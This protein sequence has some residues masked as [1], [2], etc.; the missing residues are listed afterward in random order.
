MEI[1][2]LIAKFSKA[3][4]PYIIWIC[5][6]LA[7]RAHS[8][9]LYLYRVNASLLSNYQKAISTAF[10]SNDIIIHGIKNAST[11]LDCVMPS[12]SV[13]ISYSTRYNM[14]LILLR[15][16]S[17]GTWGNRLKECLQRRLI[18]AC[19]DS[20]CMEVCHKNSIPNCVRLN[21]PV[22]PAS[23]FGEN[24]FNFITYLKYE[25]ILAAL[26]IADH[27]LF[28]DA[29]VLLFR[30]P[31]LDIYFDRNMSSGKR[32]GVS[33]YDFQYQREQG[34]SYSCA[35]TVNGGQLYFRKTAK[36]IKVLEQMISNK[37][38]I[39]ESDNGLADQD[40]LEKYVK[41]YN[42]STCSLSPD[43]FRGHCLHGHRMGLKNL[44]WLN[45]DIITYHSTCLIG[46]EE[47]MAVLHQ[48][49]SAITARASKI[50]NGYLER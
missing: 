47:K 29:D 20:T 35:G 37:T 45:T 32:G 44:S 36:S 2:R 31:W 30:N 11:S 34:T 46:A 8:E 24:A 27:V 14:D 41:L 21:L 18:I 23:D 50:N 40:L 13:I 19:L 4:A 26:N 6:L 22:L 42:L 3:I 28:I 17:M 48:I 49:V 7:N 9:S 33:K 15:H 10:Q 16:K 43:L 12:S 39:I 25:L 5:I 38:F 1:L